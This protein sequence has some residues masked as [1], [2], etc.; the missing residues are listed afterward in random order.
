VLIAEMTWREA[1]RAIAADRPMIVP[2]GSVE[3][4]GHH[5][6]LSTDSLIAEGIAKRVA[7]RVQGVV[8]PTIHYTPHSRPAAGGGDNRFPGSI[9]VP[10]RVLEQV[11]DHICAELF[12]QGVRRVVFLNGHFENIAPITEALTDVVQRSQGY[13]AML[14]S[15]PDVISEEQ[16][17]EHL[18]GFTS[19]HLEHAAGSEASCVAALRPE[20]FHSE[21]AGDGGVDRFAA[22]DV[23]P[24]PPEL[25]PPTGMMGDATAASAEVGE[26]ILGLAVAGIVRAIEQDLP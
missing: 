24:A 1:E 5:L 10:G 20:L 8:A 22:Y 13:S 23:F 17:R 4:H 25:I 7:E 14:I 2:V 21:L 16:W 11:I 26:R 9:G 12:R 18:P 19:F 15:W 6:P 3:Q